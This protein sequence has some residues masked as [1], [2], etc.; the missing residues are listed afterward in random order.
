M[1]NLSLN[2]DQIV[3]ESF[4]TEAP[5]SPEA[6]VRPRTYEPGCTADFCRAQDQL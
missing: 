1:P 5:T 4:P 6:A 2:A 3:V